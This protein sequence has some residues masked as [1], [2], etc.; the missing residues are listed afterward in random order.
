MTS[1]KDQN[2]KLSTAADNADVEENLQ[3]EESVEK[4]SDGTEENHEGVEKQNTPEHTVAIAENTREDSGPDTDSKMPSKWKVG[5]VVKF[6]PHINS[7]FLEVA[8]ITSVNYDEESYNYNLKFLVG[9]RTAKSV[10]ESRI[11]HQDHP[12]EMEDDGDVLSMASSAEISKQSDSL[13]NTRSSRRRTTRST[14]NSSPSIPSSIAKSTPER[15]QEHSDQDMEAEQGSKTVTQRKSRRRNTG[16]ASA[17]DNDATRL[18]TRPP[19]PKKDLV[20]STAAA[21]VA[22]ASRS[23]RSRPTKKDIVESPEPTRRSTRQRKPKKFDDESVDSVQSPRSTR[24][25]GRGKQ[26]AEESAPAK[27]RKQKKSA[28]DDVSVASTRS[29]RST[30]RKRGKEDAEEESV[31][32][33]TS[34]KQKKPADDDVSVA[35]TRS[36]RSATRRAKR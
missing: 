24:G 17:A 10:E 7:H 18:S 19:R 3:S 33:K 13:M 1:E 6:R 16:S 4:V 28:D 34:R 36:T 23:V 15:G 30:T 9:R 12:D 20:A 31:P 27:T 25:T 8:K 35:S 5:D 22:P 11:F 26:N 29:T 2:S 21:I 32:A 14:P